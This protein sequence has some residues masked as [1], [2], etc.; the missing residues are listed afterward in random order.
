MNKLR[1][2][3][4]LKGMNQRQLSELFHTPQSLVS[5]IEIG[6]LKP[7]TAVAQRMS[8]ALGMPM[9]DLFPELRYNLRQ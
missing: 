4:E 6:K 7:W 8:D 9:E 3:R 1:Q 2:A 5:A